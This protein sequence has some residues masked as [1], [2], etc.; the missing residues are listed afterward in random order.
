MRLDVR[1]ALQ[2]AVR[3]QDLEKGPLNIEASR[4]RAFVEVAIRHTV[5]SAKDHYR[6]PLCGRGHGQK[7]PNT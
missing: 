3:Y 1:Y 4:A 7:R 5:I 2:H 6:F